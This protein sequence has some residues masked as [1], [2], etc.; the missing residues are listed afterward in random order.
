MRR[1]SDILADARQRVDDLSQYERAARS[2]I[3]PSTTERGGLQLRRREIVNRI[4]EIE[5][6]ATLLA[7]R[8]SHEDAILKL[9]GA[10]EERKALAAETPPDSVGDRPAILKAAEAVAEA[11]MKQG[12]ADLLAELEREVVAIAQRFGF[13]GLEGIGIRGNGITLTVS[14]VASGYGKQTAGQRLRLR[15]AIVVAMMR[16]A[17][18]SGFGHHPGVLFLD[19]PGSEEL[20]DD[21]LLAMLQEIGQVAAE[22]KSLQ[23]FVASARGELLGPA[24]E[25]TNI[26]GPVAS[27]TIF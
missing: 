18:R 19:S 13:R 9:T 3:E 25:R 10:L 6:Q 11:R 5:A 1:P 15:I 26:I 7:Q 14:G 20:S 16:F 12:S 2:G 17:E 21:D 4:G 8:R 24:F 22:T 27:G 23:I